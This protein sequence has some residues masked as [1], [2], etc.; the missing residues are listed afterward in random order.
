M[1]QTIKMIDCKCNLCGSGYRVSEGTDQPYCGMI[2]EERSYKHDKEQMKSII[3]KKHNMVI[4]K[5]DMAY[6]IEEGRLDDTHV[7]LNGF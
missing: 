7:L 6:R 4:W 3:A 1:T 2:C 5:R